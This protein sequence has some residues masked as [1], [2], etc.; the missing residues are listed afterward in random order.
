MIFLIH[1]LGL[2]T[3]ALPVCVAEKIS[4]F[5]GFL[6]FT[7]MRS[8]RNMML[9]NLHHCFPE[10]TERER[11]AIALESACRTVEMGMF[12]LA[13]PYFSEK[14]IRKQFS[15]DN[16]KLDALLDENC[17]LVVGVPHFSLM[18]VL[19]MIP[20]FN[21]K[22]RRRK[23][24]VF[25]RPFDNRSIEN[26]VRSTRERFGFKLLSRKKGLTQA[27]SFLDNNGIVCVLFDQSAG[28]RRGIL[29][30]FANRVG[31]SSMLAGTL[32]AGKPNTRLVTVYCERKG[33]WQGRIVVE[34]PEVAERNSV[35]YTIAL[36]RWLERKLASNDDVCAD[37]LWLHDRWKGFK[38][39]NLIHKKSILP[40]TLKVCGLKEMPREKR[41]WIRLPNW[42]G[43]IV[44]AFPL[45]QTIR[46]ARPDAQITL[47]ARKHFLPMLEIL[48]VADRLIALPP[49]GKGY[50]KFCRSLSA[51]YPDQHLLFTNSLR[52]DLEAK[53][54]GAPQRIGMVRKG[55]PRP[56]INSK[57]NVPADSDL[58][59]NHQTHVWARWLKED[60]GLVAA[61]DFSPI[62]IESEKKFRVG[63]I[64]GTE[65]S[66]E[67]RWPVERWRELISLLQKTF[68]QLE[69]YLFGTAKDGA[70]TAQVSDGQNEKIVDRA[71]KTDLPAYMRE[72]S[73]CRAICGNDTGGMHLANMLG[74]PVVGIF[75]P[76]NPIRTG[77]IF[78]ASVTILQPENCPP[79]GGAD[80]RG[81]SAERAHD[82]LAGILKNHENA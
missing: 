64:C 1:L 76:T 42:L 24:G 31:T 55:Y 2:F 50:W 26:W 10:K 54:M 30:L 80:I 7:L 57:W 21:E 67:K 51:E 81:V 35:G 59:K 70:I 58:A 48:G 20:L 4:K 11:R 34:T 77:P 18:E 60:C 33:F 45:I 53:L 56:L 72:L 38:G 68:P 66:P 40:E 63:L 23:C 49:K 32:L 27:I 79:T 71:G 46:A 62:K 5:L 22:I 14:R 17:P 41:I 74:V 73:S 13:S 69:I 78:A 29:S 9:R 3:A 37:W 61:L 28:K 16:A 19:T 43:D 8:R 39:F 52:G 65:N 25:Y 15:L 44:M 82:A 12:V 75:G 47:L 36:N 6:V